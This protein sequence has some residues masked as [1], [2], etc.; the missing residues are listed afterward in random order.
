MSESAYSLLKLERSGYVAILTL[1]RPDKLNALNRDLVVQFHEALD[2]IG[3]DKN[4]RVLVITGEGKGFCSGA[5]VR[6]QL[7]SLE[8]VVEPGDES[9]GPSTTELGP[10]L[11]IIPQ[12][13]ISAVHGIAAGAGLAISLASDIRIASEDAKFSCLFVKRSLVPD[14][15]SSYTLPK[16]VGYGIAKEMAL[17]GNIYDANWAL[18]KGLVN[19]VVPS[20]SLIVE[21]LKLA[22]TIASNPPIAVRSIK[23]LINEHEEELYT[24]LPKEHSANGPATGSQ[25]R[26]EAVRSFLEKR[27]PV[28][29]DM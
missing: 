8:G 27:Q 7:Q 2:E 5:D 3:D 14:T 4:L 19:M 18:E 24:I 10:H 17:T 1:N 11:R 20:E 25:D 28:Y 22:E 21:A 9:R 6:G 23:R 29:K 26:M 12:P 13:V 15:A 16:L